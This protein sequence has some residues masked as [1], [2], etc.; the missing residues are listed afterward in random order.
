MPSPNPIESIAKAIEEGLSLWKTFI[1]TRQQAYDRSMDKKMRRA[2]NA[3][4]RIALRVKELGISDKQ[5]LEDVDE[6]FKYNN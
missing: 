5:I 2:I 3:G 4:E 6:F 1:A